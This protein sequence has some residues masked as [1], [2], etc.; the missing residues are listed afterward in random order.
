MNQDET[1]EP[2][3][4]N[5]DEVEVIPPPESLA[6]EQRSL[7]NLLADGGPPAEELTAQLGEQ[8]ILPLVKALNT[9]NENY[10]YNAA[11]CLAHLDEPL[12]TEQL[13]ALLNHSNLDVRSEA[14]AALEQ[15]YDPGF[16]DK[17]IQLTGKLKD[18]WIRGRLAM[19]LARDGGGAI[20]DKIHELRGY[21]L[22]TEVLRR[23]DLALARL[24]DLEARQRVAGKLNH[25][26]R[27]VC[28]DAIRDYIYIDDIASL[29][30]LRPLLDRTEP[31]LNVRPAHSNFETWL[32]T[33]DIAAEVVIVVAGLPIGKEIPNFGRSPLNFDQ[34]AVVKEY[35]DQRK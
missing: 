14:I 34:I 32:R 10:C 8:S 18:H 35:L 4:S 7:W 16:R 31:L 26:V 24:G 13:I 9:S 33:C 25:P 29:Q 2:D 17:L 27:E 11:L 28:V 30:D 15:S 5:E 22:D 3:F 23:Y 21:E 1:S 19:I 12:R 6:P 20:T